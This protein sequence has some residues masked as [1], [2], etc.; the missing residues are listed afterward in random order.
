[1]ADKETILRQYNLNAQELTKLFD[2][3][4]SRLENDG[5]TVQFSDLGPVIETN[6]YMSDMLARVDQHKAEQAQEQGHHETC[7]SD[8]QTVFLHHDLEDVGGITGR[9][10]DILH[11]GL[12]HAYQWGAGETDGLRFYGDAAWDIGSRF[13]MFASEKE[14]DV[15]RAYEKEGSRVALGNL[16]KIFRE[17]AFSDGFVKEYTRFFIDQATTD[18]DYIIDYYRTG[19]ARH[20]FE[21]WHGSSSLLPL[22]I[23]TPIAA[24]KREK[25]AVPLISRR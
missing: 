4:V 7:V 12:G 10:Y 18:L 9:L 3:I 14:L 5:I 6:I 25:P 20:F 19:E 24:K 13:F 11:V 23:C 2:C 17:N 16:Q 21:N 1:M 8:G 15:V 22:D